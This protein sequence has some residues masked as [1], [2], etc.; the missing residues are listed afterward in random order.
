MEVISL[1]TALASPLLMDAP[2]HTRQVRYERGFWPTI[3]SC[4]SMTC[5]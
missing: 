3:E 2:P 5:Y 4:R 1:M